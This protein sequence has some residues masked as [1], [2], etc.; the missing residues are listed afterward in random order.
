[1]ALK[2]PRRLM[3]DKRLP[4]ADKQTIDE[5]NECLDRLNGLRAV[6]INVSGRA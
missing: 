4:E 2:Q 3:W 5:L 6:E 1:M